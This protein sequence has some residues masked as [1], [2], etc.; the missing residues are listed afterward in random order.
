VTILR[1]PSCPGNGRGKHDETERNRKLPFY[2]FTKI[3]V[4][5][6][7]S[8]GNIRREPWPEPLGS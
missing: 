8:A 6:L 2:V 1:R 4:V 3:L 5:L 7:F